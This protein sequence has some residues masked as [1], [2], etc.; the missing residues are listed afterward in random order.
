MRKVLMGMALVVVALVLAG[1][2]LVRPALA[3]GQ[4]CVR[5]GGDLVVAA[6]ESCSGDAIAIG[7]DLVVQG[8][9]GGNAVSLGGS[10]QVE[11]RVAGDVVSVGGE[12][13]LQDGA[14][15]E[16]NVTALGGSLR[17]APGA[18]VRGNIVES[19]VVLPVWSSREGQP[20][21][22]VG[23]RL[24]AALLSSGLAFGLCL[25]VALVLRS[26]W[27]QRTEVM[28]ATLRHEFAIS[29]GMGLVS[30]VLLALAVPL[31]T[32]FLAVIII[33]IIAIPFLYILLVLVYVVALTITGLALGEVLIA[34]V[35]RNHP[36]QWL[37]AALGLAIL[38]PLTIIPG[39]LIPCLG[40][41]WVGFV[42]CGGVGAIVL[43]RL[44]T[45]CRP[46]VRPGG[47]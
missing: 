30:G 32:I 2:V 18:V 22:S 45:L 16:G 47:M 21:V 44:G 28:V 11:G 36:P 13:Q 20:L 39:V 8:S 43:S 7:G 4:A 9:V 31:L 17:R 24:L 1:F 19:G 42:P 6:G 14:Q 5:I 25:L 33:G 27:P 3:Q 46:A 26:V 34:R 23:L 37:A 15:V 29:V 40:P 35:G 38:V 41:L 10:V 12:V